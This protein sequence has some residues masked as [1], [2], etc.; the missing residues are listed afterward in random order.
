MYVGLEHCSNCSGVLS[1]SK[2]AKPPIKWAGG[3]TQLL[4]QLR[5]L[6]PEG[7]NLY[8]EPFVGGG[9]VF[10]DLQP[11]RA[12][13][14]DSNYELINFYQVVKN[15]LE[16]LLR[17]LKKHK[18]SKEYYYKIRS[19]DPDQMDSIERASRFLY[20]NKTC[21]N[22]LWRVNKRGQFN[23][24]FGRYKNPNYRDKENLCMVSAALQ[25]AEIICDDFSIVL[26]Y[27]SLGDF[28]Y[29]DP[30]YHPLSKTANFTNYTEEPFDEQDQMRLVEVFRELD[31][32]NCN[33]MLSNSDT[34]FIR[35]LY[36]GYD[37]KTVYAKRAINSKG[38]KRGPVKELVIRNYH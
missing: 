23:V 24:P 31:A 11:N 20:L 3:K 5:P 10:F 16:E 28:V 19:L 33:V 30:P 26:D 21:F 38:D 25:N 13:L 8:L 1:F 15:N 6:F 14:I 17:D 12:V 7:F 2:Q 32:R 4:S 27:V 29:L 9:A 22:G 35:S 37:I 36:K 34:E 18:N